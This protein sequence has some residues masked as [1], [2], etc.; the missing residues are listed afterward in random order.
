M[1]D[2]LYLWNQPG[3][4]RLVASGV[5]FCDLVPALQRP[6]RAGI[7]LLRHQFEGA[8]RD[9]GSRLEFVSADDLQQM[10]DADVRGYGDFC[11]ADFAATAR[12]ADLPDASVAVLTFF[13]HAARPL[14]GRI[15]DPKLGNRLLCWAHDDGWYLRLFY[16]RWDALAPVLTRLLRVLLSDDE[17]ASSRVLRALERDDAAFW[18]DSRRGVIECERSDDIDALQQKYYA[19]S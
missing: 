8:E 15:A 17:R 16:D 6:D 12:L 1:R 11:W 3:A 4:R 2:Y 10:A 5:E 9:P 14:D 7:V 19:A 13:T 18:C